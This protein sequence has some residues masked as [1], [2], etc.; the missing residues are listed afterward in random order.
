MKGKRMRLAFMVTT[1]AGIRRYNRAYL[2]HDR[3]TDVIAFGYPGRDP[4][5]KRKELAGDIVISAEQA[6]KQARRFGTTFKQ[7]MELYIVHGILHLLGYKDHT[8]RESARMRAKEAWVLK[9]AHARH[10]YL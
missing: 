10:A 4:V 1:N 5:T 2:R 3:P 7:E 6:R 8:P 9:R